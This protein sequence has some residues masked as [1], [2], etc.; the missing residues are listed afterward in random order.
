MKKS[1]A[2]K[3]LQDYIDHNAGFLVPEQFLNFAEGLGMLPPHGLTSNYAEA[4]GEYGIVFSHPETP[5]IK[6]FHSWEP[7]S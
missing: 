7:E 5:Y 1:E 6:Y 3:K 2:I 4:N